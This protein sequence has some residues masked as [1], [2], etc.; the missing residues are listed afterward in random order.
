MLR[1]ALGQTDLD[2]E[3]VGF[4][5]TPANDRIELFHLDMLL[6]M[7]FYSS[8]P[9]DCQPWSYTSAVWFTA[10]RLRNACTITATIS[11]LQTNMITRSVVTSRLSP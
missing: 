10:R 6:R 5:R 9:H 11:T 8:L 7:L 1:V 4:T 2:Q 3:K